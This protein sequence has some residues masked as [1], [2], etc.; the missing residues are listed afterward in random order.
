MQTSDPQRRVWVFDLPEQPERDPLS[1]VFWARSAR[2]N[3]RVK[4]KPVLIVA[5]SL[6]G[7]GIFVWG[8]DYFTGSFPTF[9]DLKGIATQDDQAKWQYSIPGSWCDY[10]AGFAVLFVLSLCIQFRK[11]SQDGHYHRKHRKDSYLQA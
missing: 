7:A 10:L 4:E 5:T 2:R 8:I 1:A 6:F 3:T 9:T 11:T